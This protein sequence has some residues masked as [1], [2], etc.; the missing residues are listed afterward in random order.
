MTPHTDLL[1]RESSLVQPVVE[2]VGRHLRARVLLRVVAPWG[3]VVGLGT[4]T[5]GLSTSFPSG[6]GSLGWSAHSS[7]RRSFSATAAHAGAVATPIGNRHALCAVILRSTESLRSHFRAPTLERLNDM[8][9]LCGGP[10]DMWRWRV[11]LLSFLLV[12][13]NECALRLYE[14]LGHWSHC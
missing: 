4:P 12:R 14:E 11:K 3:A 8:L 5:R 7:A 13:K 9:T 10:G 6:P 1:D 2:R